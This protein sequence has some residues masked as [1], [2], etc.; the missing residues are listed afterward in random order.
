MQILFNTAVYM[1]CSLFCGNLV[2][3]KKKKPA[4]L[5]RIQDKMNAF[6]VIH[7]Y[8]LFTW[9]KDLVC[10][11]CE[12]SKHPALNPTWHACDPSASNCNYNFSN[13]IFLM[14]MWLALDM[15]LV[16]MLS[17]AVC[18]TTWRWNKRKKSIN[19]Q[20]DLMFGPKCHW[21]KKSIFFQVERYT[22][23]IIIIYW[24]DI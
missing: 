17:R 19:I 7:R 14:Q 8:W 12:G 11:T 2:F 16:W 13:M 23:T 18:N 4:K 6:T 22:R 1:Q 24:Y 5:C 21:V 9:T 10:R 15:N 20:P 3:R